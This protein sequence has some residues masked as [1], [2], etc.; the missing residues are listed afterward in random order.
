MT[1]PIHKKLH[2]RPINYPWGGSMFTIVSFYSA[3][4]FCLCNK[5]QPEVNL[6][7]P[8]DA[9]FRLCQCMWALWPKSDSNTTSLFYLFRFDALP[10]H[11]AWSNVEIKVSKVLLWAS[12]IEQTHFV[13]SLSSWWTLKTFDTLCLT[14]CTRTPLKH[15]RKCPNRFTQWVK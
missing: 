15:F 8:S 12:K 5:S 9:L 11:L 1:C 6:P 3:C 2:P 13:P 4:L 10:V 14:P 7:V